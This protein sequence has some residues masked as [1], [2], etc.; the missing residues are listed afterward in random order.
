E[1]LRVV[2]LKAEAT[3]KRVYREDKATEA[4]QAVEVSE[5]VAGPPVNI[6]P[7]TG[8]PWQTGDAVRL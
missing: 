2:E 8:L 4:A 5:P 1:R 7:A 3:R 6:N